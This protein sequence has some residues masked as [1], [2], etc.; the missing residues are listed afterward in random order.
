MFISERSH[1][2]KEFL[3][4]LLL[5]FDKRGVSWVRPEHMGRKKKLHWEYLRE[6]ALVIES[7]HFFSPEAFLTAFFV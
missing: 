2:A 7:S 3:V 5:G 4:L 6:V 1:E